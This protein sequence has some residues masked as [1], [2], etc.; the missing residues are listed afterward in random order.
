[1][2]AE[3]PA[4]VLKLLAVVAL[5]PTLRRMTIQILQ[6]MEKEAEANA[7]M[8]DVVADLRVPPSVQAPAP[9]ERVTL[10]NAPVVA[11]YRGADQ[12][13]WYDPPSADAWRP[14]GQAV[15]DRLTQTSFEKKGA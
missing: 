11:E 3:T 6:G 14:P 7:F 8:R 4:E 2:T 12:R 1:M 10:V 13:G 9:T 15:I 5:N